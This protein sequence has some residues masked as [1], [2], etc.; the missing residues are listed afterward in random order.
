[1]IRNLTTSYFGIV[2]KN[3]SDAV[4]KAIVY[5]LVKRC[6]DEL[7]KV[8]V[9]SAPPTP[10]FVVYMVA[11]FNELMV[12]YQDLLMELYKEHTFKN[13]MKESDET[14][15]V[16]VPSPGPQAGLPLLYAVVLRLARRALISALTLTPHRCER[17]HRRCWR[18]WSRRAKCSRR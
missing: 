8:C 2:K 4:P 12:A 10:V 6:A 1:M 15:Q 9:I 7:H 3:V 18:A 11:T 17:G 5:M 14:K 13:L 16:R